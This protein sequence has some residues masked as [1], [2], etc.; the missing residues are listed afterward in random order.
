M[1]RSYC[2]WRVGDPSS[3]RDSWFGELLRRRQREPAVSSFD[4]D[5]LQA[6]GSS[7]GVWGMA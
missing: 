7:E 4:Q 1:P 6:S 3:V 2:F 5:A